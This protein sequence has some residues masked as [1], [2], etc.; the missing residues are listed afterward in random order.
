L[1][2]TTILLHGGAIVRSVANYRRHD[3][4]SRNA[5]SEL[6]LQLSRERFSALKQTHQGGLLAGFSAVT[7][8]S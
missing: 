5:L 8:V 4:M 1:W 6:G 3:R 7:V 2:N